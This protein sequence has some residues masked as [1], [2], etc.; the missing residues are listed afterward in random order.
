MQLQPGRNCIVGDGLTVVDVA[1]NLDGVQVCVC[2]GGGGAFVSGR[3][4]EGNGRG[5]DEKG[6]PG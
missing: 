3:A 4:H 2:G 6:G 1:L 5:R